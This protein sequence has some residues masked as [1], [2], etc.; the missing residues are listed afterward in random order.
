LEARLVGKP[1]LAQRAEA[2]NAVQRGPAGAPL[3]QQ[4]AATEAVGGQK[5]PVFP[6]ETGISSIF[7]TQPSFGCKNGSENQVLACEFPW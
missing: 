6:V 3:A 7:P 2:E 4:A 1:D 5:L